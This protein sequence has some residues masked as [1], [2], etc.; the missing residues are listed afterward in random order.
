MKILVV[1]DDLEL[2]ALISFTLRQAGYLTLEAKDG[3]AA[4]ELFEREAPQLVLLDVN[5]PGISGLEVCRRM[6]TTSRVPVMMLTVRSGEDDQV[7]ALDLGAD[8]YLTKPFSPRTLLARVRAL[9]RRAE[10]GGGERAA[11]LEVGP[12]SLDVER[13]SVQVAG[14]GPIRL[15]RLELKLLQLL[16]A[17][18]GATLPAERLLRYVWGSR[19]SDDRQLLKQLVHRLRQKIE[20]DAAHPRYLLTESGVGYVLR[21]EGGG[22]LS[23]LQR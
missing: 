3:A 5:L 13:Q 7:A 8:D 4:L 14:R 21:T 23:S 6:R 20:E 15:T 11:P 10:G 16:L 19:A 12:F 2:L 17:N 9:L 18:A 1:D 22:G